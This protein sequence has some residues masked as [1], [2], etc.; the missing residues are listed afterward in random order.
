MENNENKTILVTGF[1]PFGKHIVNASWEAVKE[2]KKMSEDLKETFGVNLI[3]EKVPVVYE[4][5]SKKIPQLWVE[6]KPMVTYIKIQ[7]LQE[8]I[9]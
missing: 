7:N 9:S 2:L 6:H 5:V 4:Y 1:G 8:L 3:T